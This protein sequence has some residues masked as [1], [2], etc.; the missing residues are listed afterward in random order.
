MMGLQVFIQEVGG[1]AFSGGVTDE[2]NLSRRSDI[3]RDLFK[4]RA[5]GLKQLH[6]GIDDIL[7]PVS[8]TSVIRTLQSIRKYEQYHRPIAR[9]IVLWPNIAN[10]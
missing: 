4:A 10:T 2:D 5:T 8:D 3:F 1:V 7:Y 9:T 6:L